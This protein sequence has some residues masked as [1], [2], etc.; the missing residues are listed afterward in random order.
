MTGNERYERAANK[1]MIL[2]DN[3]HVKDLYGWC[4]RAGGQTALDSY[5]SV[6]H[7]AAGKQQLNTTPIMHA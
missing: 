6:A 1:L 2:G 4:S 3:D 5:D 7:P